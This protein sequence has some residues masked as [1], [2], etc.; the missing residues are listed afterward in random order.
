MRVKLLIATNI[1]AVLSVS[2]A[3]PRRI[4]PVI[5]FHK[6]VVDFNDSVSWPQLNQRNFVA[7]KK[8]DQQQAAA[9]IKPPIQVKPDN[10][11][12][13]LPVQMDCDQSKVEQKNNKPTVSEGQR[14]LLALVREIVHINLTV[15]ARMQDRL[16]IEEFVLDAYQKNPRLQKYTYEAVSRS[17]WYLLHKEKLFLMSRK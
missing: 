7:P 8:N 3:Q 12:Q 11:D 17:F 10:V 15:Y 6:I 1:A 16:W 4:P 9:A 2:A 14:Y 5:R 13:E